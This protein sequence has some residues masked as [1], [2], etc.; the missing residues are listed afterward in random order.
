MRVKIYLTADGSGAGVA[1]VLYIEDKPGAR[2][3]PHP[4]GQ[5]WMYF[6]TVDRHDPILAAE[7]SQIAA[8]L[9]TGEAY[10]GHCLPL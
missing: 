7:S 3:P 10:V 8:A 6:A 1:P 9:E 5:S 4:N 2:V